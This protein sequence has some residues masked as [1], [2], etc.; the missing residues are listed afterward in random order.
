GK[1]GA[2]RARR[3]GNAAAR[4]ARARGKPG[5]GEGPARGRAGAERAGH[6]EAGRGGKCR[7]WACSPLTASRAVPSRLL[8]RV[9][10]VSDSAGWAVGAG[11]GKAIAWLTADGWDW[12]AFEVMW[13]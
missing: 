13:R 11:R 1:P 3:G 5:R 8:S 12:T 6:V 2:E 4:K 10:C 9:P 7:A